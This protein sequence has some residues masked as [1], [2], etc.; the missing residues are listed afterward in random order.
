MTSKARVR[1]SVGTAIFAVNAAVFLGMALWEGWQ[2]YRESPLPETDMMLS[3]A[4][5]HIYAAI[6]AVSAMLAAF[7]VLAEHYHIVS[8]LVIILML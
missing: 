5:I 6:G 2:W 7:R 3:I 1:N 4:R 8:R